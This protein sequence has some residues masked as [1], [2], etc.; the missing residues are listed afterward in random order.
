MF[1]RCK[2][3]DITY[4]LGMWSI[5]FMIVLGPAGLGKGLGMPRRLKAP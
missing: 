5:V 2:F 3:I 4:K 1:L